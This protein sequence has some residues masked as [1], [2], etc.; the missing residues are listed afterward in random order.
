M[1]IKRAAPTVHS[2]PDVVVT[3]A[4][5]VD[6]A[7]M[8]NSD[9]LNQ[10]EEVQPAAA[11]PGLPPLPAMTP[12]IETETSPIPVQEQRRGAAQSTGSK[13]KSTLK[14]FKKTI[15]VIADENFRQMPKR[16]AKEKVG[17]KVGD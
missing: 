12:P 1:K 2:T 8:D 15:E 16:K 11:G 9:Q 17:S 5:A 6:P 13:S 3:S 10:V 14:S 7:S 4:D